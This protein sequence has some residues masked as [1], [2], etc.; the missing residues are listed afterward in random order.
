MIPNCYMQ[1]FSKVSFEFALLLTTNCK[2][3]LHEKYSMVC[4][5]QQVAPSEESEFTSLCTL[6]EARGIICIK[7]AKDVRMSK[8]ERKM[9]LYFFYIKYNAKV[10]INE[11]VSGDI[12][13]GRRGVG[14][15]FTRQ[16]PHVQYSTTGTLM[17]QQGILEN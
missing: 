10:L 3:Q 16:S 9:F 14:T 12:E 11:H 4:R 1:T 6:V 2:F 5:R 17:P 15:C 13:T 7:K 8:V